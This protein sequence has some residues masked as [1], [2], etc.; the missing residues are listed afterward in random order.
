MFT[1]IVEAVATICRS[2]DGELQCVRPAEFHSV[3][4]GASIAVCGVCLTVTKATSKTLSFDCAPETQR[5]TTLG[6]L[7]E[8]DAVNLERAMEAHARI[9]G[10]LVQGHVEGVGEVIEVSSVSLGSARSFK[11]I[12]AD[13]TSRRG[14]RGAKRLRHSNTSFMVCIRV[15]RELLSGIIPRGS[16]AIDGVSLTVANI[17]QNL[18]SIQVVPYTASHT[19]L[20]MLKA[21]DKVNI[22]TD[23]LVRAALR[24]KG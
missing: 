19:T 24:V 18:C 12:E 15:P 7:K 14:G 21:G 2:H 6:S 20:G 9:D 3:K 10:H 22:E 13:A 4:P 5:V 17:E 23:I 16:I 8:G 11:N 1:G